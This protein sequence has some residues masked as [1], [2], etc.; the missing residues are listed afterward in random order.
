MAILGD[1]TRVQQFAGGGAG[2]GGTLAIRQY[3]DEPGQGRLMQ[4]S[5]LYGLGTGVLASAMWWADIDVPLIADEF[6]A[7]HAMTA[8]PSGMFMAAFPKKSGTTTTEQVR[9]ALPSLYNPQSSR[10]TSRVA[11]REGAEVRINES[12]GRSRRRTRT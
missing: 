5:V 3:M 9:S 12:S 6:W 2:L 8:L 11:E 1:T 7:S 10:S 4:P